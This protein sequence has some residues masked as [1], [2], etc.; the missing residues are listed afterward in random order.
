M[1]TASTTVESGPVDAS[2]S[3]ATRI[4]R[5]LGKTPVYLFLVFVGLL[6]LVPTIGLLF[7]SLA[8]WALNALIIGLSLH[9]FAIEVPWFVSLILAGVVAFAVAVPSAP[10]FFGIVQVCFV[11]VLE[12]FE[13][14]QEQVFAAPIYFHL[15]QYIPVTLSGFAYF[16]VQGMK[17]ADVR[18]EAEQERVDPG[19]ASAEPASHPS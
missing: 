15:L 16:S 8:Q 19:A 12:L 6:W 5:V 3:I 14:D 13:A 11:A 7:T 18:H 4:V 10:G 17:L 2:E 9:A 1:S